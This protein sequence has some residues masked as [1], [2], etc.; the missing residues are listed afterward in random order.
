MEL[1]TAKRPAPGEKVAP[2]SGPMAL[3]GYSAE[4]MEAAMRIGLDFV[5]V[6]PNGFE[7]LLEKD[8]VPV[9]PWD[10]NRRNEESHL[11]YEELSR[12][13]VRWSVPLYEETVEW[14]GAIN[15][16]LA[17]SP[18]IFTH[19]LLFRDKAMMKRRAQ[20][21][22]IRV[23][24]FE[25]VDS[26][27][28]VH[29]F[30]R[31]VNDALVGVGPDRENGVSPVHLK[32]ISAAGSV[33][34][35]LIR[36]DEDIA[37]IADDAFPCMVESHLD[38][39]EFSCEAFIHD[40]KVRF[41][42][43]NEYVHLGHCQLTPAG[44]GLQSIRSQI[45]QEVERL[46]KAFDVRHGLLHPE[47][48]LDA[49][50]ELNFGEVANRVPGGHIFDLIEMAHGFDP[51][52]GLLLCSDPET[53]EDELEKLFP[54]VGESPRGHAAN[55]MVYPRKQRVRELCI[56]EEVREDPYFMKHDLVE[57]MISKVPSREGFGNHYGQIV[58]F[59]PDP[60][61]MREIL[62]KYEDLD[63]YV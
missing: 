8:G 20:M 24:V 45:M 13:G 26:R 42:N 44:P 40:G 36:S 17:D 50:G 35:V 16:R 57:P 15:S 58:F 21:S 51:F 30:F 22:G 32:P 18:Q 60:L 23:G 4:T 27:T 34:H 29:R 61:R 59:G 14:A 54:A 37:A 33:G 63:Y 3:L 53:R 56:P 12:R 25:E 41:L 55:L 31:R 49:D 5:A 10:F 6:V 28:Q 2:R 9:V 46:A 52:A 39:Q 1:A 7:S 38:G 62:K 19:S 11:L 47:Y 48:F 43:I